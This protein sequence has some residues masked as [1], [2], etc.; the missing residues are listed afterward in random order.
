MTGK[1]ILQTVRCIVRE[2]TMEDMEELFALYEPP[3]LTRFVEP[4]FDRDEEIAYQRNYIRYIYGGYGYGLWAVIERD[5]GAMIGR[6]GVESRPEDPLDT[7]ELGAV[8][9]QNRQ[10]RGLAT[11]VCR[12]VLGYADTVLKKRH[13]YARIH[14]EN[15]P[16]IRLVRRLGFERT[17]RMIEGEDVWGRALP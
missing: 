2:I 6:I 5:S 3:E 10:G 16:S 13:V 1:W 11:E 4:L 9:A 7:V 14:P 17:G 12:A 8:V 15:E